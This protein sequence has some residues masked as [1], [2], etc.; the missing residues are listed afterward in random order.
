MPSRDVSEFYCYEKHENNKILPKRKNRHQIPQHSRGDIK[1]FD[2]SLE[3][4]DCHTQV[5][6]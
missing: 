3:K 5:C 6:V 4:L 2:K 1:K